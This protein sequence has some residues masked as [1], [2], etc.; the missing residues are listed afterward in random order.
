MM[1]IEDIQDAINK[2]SLYDDESYFEKIY[3]AYYNKLLRLSLSIVKSEEIAEEI[4]DDVMMNI[5]EKRKQLSHI[6]NFTV[7]LYVS[8]KNAS[9]RYLSRS[10]KISNVDINDI[11]IEIEDM[12]PTAQEQMIALEFMEKINTTI[13][14]LSPQCKLVFKLVKED[15][16]KYKEVAEILDISI[17]NVEYHMGN[18]LKKISTTISSDF[19]LL[20][21][22]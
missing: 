9:L 15:G 2:I 17:K 5:W 13:S 3:T 19:K 1:N 16:L 22:K 21:T 4:Y 18:A 6:N 11:T 12:S 14:Q 8:I 20:L 10:S 7:Y